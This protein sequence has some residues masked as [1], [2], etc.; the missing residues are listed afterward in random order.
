LIFYAGLTLAISYFITYLRATGRLVPVENITFENQGDTT[1]GLTEW[2]WKNFWEMM[3][4]SLTWFLQIP[5]AVLTIILAL[6]L[7]PYQQGRDDGLKQIAQHQQYGC[8]EKDTLAA[9]TQCIY[10]FDLSKSDNYKPIAQ[11][12]LVAADK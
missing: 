7:W 10:I 6:A 1:L 11:G 8:T 5:F 12:V 3:E 9:M 2:V 4:K